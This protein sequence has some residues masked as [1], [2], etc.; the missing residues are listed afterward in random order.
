MGIHAPRTSGRRALAALVCTAILLG[1]CSSDDDEPSSGTT[2]TDGGASSTSSADGVETDEGDAPGGPLERYADYESISYD[3]SSRWLCR[4][5]ADDVCDEDLDATV[6]AEDGTV[7]VEEFEPAADPPIDCFYVYPT[8][9]RDET[10]TSDWEAS[11]AEEGYAVLNQAARLQSQCR[12]FAPVYR[13]N[14]LT[15]LT[16]NLG[17]GDV[18]VPE[19]DDPPESPYAD[20]LDA[21]RTYMAQDN[22]G[23]GVVLIGHSQGSSMLNQ[24]IR[25]EIDPNDD[26]RATLV[27]AY[28]AGWSVAVPEGELVGGDFANVPVCTDTNQTGCVLSWVSFRSTAPPPADSFF[29]KPR[30]GANAEAASGMAVCTNPADLSGADAELHAYFPANRTASILSD[31]DMEEP[32]TDGWLPSA[33]DDITTPYVSVP[34]LVRGSCHLTDGFHYLSIDVTPGDGPRADDIGG[35]LTPQWGLHLVDVSLV[36]GDVVALVEQQSTAFTG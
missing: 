31:L 20:V 15:S 29:G 6:V 34:G 17:G 30:A 36:M 35:D 32:A 9:S 27:S 24:L 3:D 25:E 13:Q 19:A 12:L 7:T 5:D 14:T 22:D 11:P 33:P 26:V 21:F 2:T 18:E 1:A 23:R 4:P 16:A 10:R 8:I 28:L